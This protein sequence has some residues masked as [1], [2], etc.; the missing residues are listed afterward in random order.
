M[1]YENVEQ[2]YSAIKTSG[3]VPLEVQAVLTPKLC[4]IL[5]KHLVE[6][7]TY[8]KIAKVYGTSVSYPYT[9]KRETELRLKEWIFEGGK[10]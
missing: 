10:N 6:N 1:K 7:L 8:Y 5:T 3:K 9:A 2:I 4:E